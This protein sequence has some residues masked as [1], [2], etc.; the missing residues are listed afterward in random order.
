MGVW[1]RLAVLGAGLYLAVDAWSWQGLIITGLVSWVVLV[2]LGEPLT[3]QDLREM[4]DGVRAGDGPLSPPLLAWLHD[5]RLLPERH[6][7]LARWLRRRAADTAAGPARDV[8]DETAAAAPGRI[9]GK[10]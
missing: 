6:R 8:R 4:A 9:A 10:G 1:A 3:G 5:H 2:I 7:R